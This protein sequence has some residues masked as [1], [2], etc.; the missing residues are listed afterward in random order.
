M[1]FFFRG[2]GAFIAI[3][4]WI[5]DL[6]PVFVQADI[7]DRPSVNPDGGNS[8]GGNAR[9]GA[10]SGEDAFENRFDVPS[11]AGWSDHRGIPKTMDDIHVRVILMEA[12][13]RNTTALRAQVDSNESFIL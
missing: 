7:I 10:Q 6:F 3:A 8:F 2:N 12:K 5:G 11:N 9:A 13:K 1:D 4:E